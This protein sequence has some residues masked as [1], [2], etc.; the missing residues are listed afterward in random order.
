METTLSPFIIH[1]GGHLKLMR[2]YSKYKKTAAADAYKKF[3]NGDTERYYSKDLD[4][5]TI[6]E[7]SEG[8]SWQKYK[9]E[10]Q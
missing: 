4:A 2:K 3:S 6:G 8:F 10:W 9:F 5:E 1:P 7:D